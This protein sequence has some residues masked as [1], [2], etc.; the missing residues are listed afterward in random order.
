MLAL[1]TLVTSKITSS[2]DRRTTNKKSS[3]LIQGAELSNAFEPMADTL[4]NIGGGGEA[5]ASIKI[6][7]APIV[8]KQKIFVLVNIVGR[9][10]LCPLVPAI[11]LGTY[12]DMTFF[13]C[14]ASKERAIWHI[15]PKKV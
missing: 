4:P 7:L 8:F 9:P 11:A 12:N 1:Q 10:P 3:V 14:L 6:I 2:T 15:A 5:I 13:L